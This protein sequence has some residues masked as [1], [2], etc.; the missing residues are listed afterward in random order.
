M[1]KIILLSTLLNTGEI[2][3]LPPDSPT[4]EARSRNG[5]NQRGRKRGGAGLR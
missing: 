4:V 5:K 1:I 3:A 2:V